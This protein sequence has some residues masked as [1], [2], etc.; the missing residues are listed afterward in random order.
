MIRSISQNHPVNPNKERQQFRGP[1]TQPGRFNAPNFLL[2]LELGLLFLCLLLSQRN[3]R[4]N[5]QK[6]PGFDKKLI[7]CANSVNYIGGDNLNIHNKLYT[8]YGDKN[9]L[10]PY[11]PEMGGLGACVGFSITAYNNPLQT[12]HLVKAM[13]LK[14]TPFTKVKKKLKKIASKTNQY[15]HGNITSLPQSLIISNEPNGQLKSTLKALTDGK[16]LVRFM[17]VN[18]EAKSHMFTLI[19]KRNQFIV[20]DQTMLTQMTPCNQ[21]E[22]IKRIIES[23]VYQTATTFKEDQKFTWTFLSKSPLPNIKNHLTNVEALIPTSHISEQHTLNLVDKMTTTELNTIVNGETFPIIFSA[24]DLESPRLV[25]ALIK[26][27]INLNIKLPKKGQPL[28]S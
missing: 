17:R 4:T 13:A 5:A 8:R 23:A 20:M 16:Y 22:V 24:I 1:T 6:P 19:K 28:Y 27:G 11:L 15:S 2:K 21:N 26:K 25:T 3:T 12:C 18:Y 14:N 10:K 9:P 7:A